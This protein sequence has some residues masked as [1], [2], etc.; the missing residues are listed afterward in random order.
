VANK[1]Y[2]LAMLPVTEII[3]IDNEFKKFSFESELVEVGDDYH[4][5][6][7][8]YEHRMALNAVLFNHWS[9][10]VVK[11]KFLRL[12]PKCPSPVKSKLHNDGSMFEGGYF[13]ISAVTKQGQISYHYKLE[14]WDKF[15]IPEVERIPW[16]YDGHSPADVIERLLSL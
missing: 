7:E 11:A 2:V 4:S 9:L 1:K 8:L 6:S 15:K 16:E 14:H 5:M 13:I 12:E 3:E 10:E